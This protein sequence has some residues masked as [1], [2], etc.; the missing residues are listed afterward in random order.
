MR[1]GFEPRSGSDQNLKIGSDCSFAKLPTFSLLRG[2]SKKILKAGLTLPTQ[3][4]ERTTKV[5][6]PAA[7]LIAGDVST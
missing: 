5:K 1:P 3:F 7:P 2:P 4:P 6:L